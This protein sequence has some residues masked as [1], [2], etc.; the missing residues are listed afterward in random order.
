MTP[1]RKDA[2]Q[3]FHDRGEVWSWQMQA[4]FWTG[5]LT[6]RLVALMKRDGQLCV[7]ILPVGTLYTLTDKGRR[8]LHEAG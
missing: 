4:G 2:L 3:W 5:H 6:E 7:E 1:A 8:D